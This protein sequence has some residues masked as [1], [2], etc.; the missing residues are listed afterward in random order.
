MIKYIIIL[1][2][3]NIHLKIGEIAKYFNISL[4]LGFEWDMMQFCHSICFLIFLFI[5]FKKIPKDNMNERSVIALFMYY[6]SYNLLAFWPLVLNKAA[7]LYPMYALI[8]IFI[9]RAYV[10][11]KRNYNEHSDTITKDNIYLCFE[12][13]MKARGVFT[14]LLGFPFCSIVIYINYHLYGFKWSKNTYIKRPIHR[15]AVTKKYIVIDTQIK[16]TDNFIFI[17]ESLIGSKARTLFLPRIK[18]IWIIRKFLKK[19]GPDF[20]PNYLEYLPSIYSKKIIGLRNEKT[21]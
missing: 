2:I 3:A 15:N 11:N 7:S 16:T 8:I 4:P 21:L 10:I 5:I 12:K 14:S 1:L 9:I 18:C 13:P 17:L 6:I 19:L 20:K